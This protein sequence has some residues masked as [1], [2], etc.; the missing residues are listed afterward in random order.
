ME[1]LRKSHQRKQFSSTKLYMQHFVSKDQFD[2]LWNV[3][4]TGIRCFHT[5]C[6]VESFIENCCI[7]DFWVNCPIWKLILFITKHFL[8]I[9]LF[10]SSLEDLFLTANKIEER[11][12]S[13]STLKCNNFLQNDPKSWNYPNSYVDNWICV[14]LKTIRRILYS[15]FCH[16]F[17]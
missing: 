13:I 4:Q 14:S 5:K 11:K 17:N 6:C 9:S 2:G 1:S 7:D 12:I 3:S 16:F 10:L 15:I 8:S